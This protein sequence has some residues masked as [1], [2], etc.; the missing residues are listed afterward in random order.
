MNI[1]KTHLYIVIITVA[2]LVL[3]VFYI[4]PFK[5][6]ATEEKLQNATKEWS[7]D[8]NGYLAYPLERGDIRF[9]RSDYGVDGNLTIHKIIYE[10]RNG[11]VY[12]ILILPDSAEELPPGIIL[13]PGSGVSKESELELAKKIAFLDVAVL[14][15][16]QRGTGETTGK[17]NDIK[18]DYADF[19]NGVE[20]SQHLMVYDVL[21]AYDLLKSAPF[22]DHGRIAIV[23]ES[24]GGRIG[25]I[26]AAL[27][28]NIE[29]VLAISASGFDFEQTNDTKVDRFLKSIDANH[30]VDLITPRKIVM[31]HNA[32]DKIIPLDAALKTFSLAEEPKQMI[33]VNDTGCNHGYCDSMYDGLVEALDYIIDI[34]SKTL[35]SVPDK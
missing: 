20:P 21:K 5:K 31:M 13:L 23:G 32:Q 2:L 9:S 35:V 33:V 30:Y 3:L 15:I 6:Q 14:V 25:I 10:S 8:K 4:K 29:G 18:Q 27:D 22:V 24:L 12:G 16:D 1:K 7:V 17:I 19:L 34:R 26:T 11:N 28:R